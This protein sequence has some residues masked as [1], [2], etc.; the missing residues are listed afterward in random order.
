MEQNG[1]KLLKVTSILMI[2]GGILGAIF[3]V[4][5]VL[6]AGVL[7]AAVNTP[8]AQQAVNDQGVSISTTTI[9]AIVWVA[10]IILVI[11]SVI[12]IIAGVKGKKNW[13]NPAAAQ[14]LIIFGIVCA[15]L[16]VLGNVLFAS[17]GAGSQIISYI[18]G[19]VLP[20]LYIIGAVQLKKQA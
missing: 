15:V 10:V 14:T 12:E 1:S 3:S 8:E 13:N 19:L 4:L 9:S 16:S 11:S 20:V 18:T 17:G 2:I 6:F 7:T 5:S